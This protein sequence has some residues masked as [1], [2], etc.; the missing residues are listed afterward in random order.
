MSEG[1]PGPSTAGPDGSD[2]RPRPWFDND[3]ERPNPRFAPPHRG[4]FQL[5]YHV[6]RLRIDLRLFSA[7]P[8]EDDARGFDLRLMS[9]V[10]DAGDIPAEGR[11]LVIVAAVGGVLHFRIF[12]GD[13]SIVVD[14]DESHL[15]AQDGPVADLKKRLENLWPTPHP[16]E[17]E[18]GQVI[19]AVTSIVGHSPAKYLLRQFKAPATQF[20]LEQAFQSLAGAAVPRAFSGFCAAYDEIDL[21]FHKLLLSLEGGTRVVVPLDAVDPAFGPLWEAFRDQADSALPAGSPLRVLYD[22]GAAIGDHQLGLLTHCARPDERGVGRP[23]PQIRRLVRALEGLPAAVIRGSPLARLI[24][25]LGPRRGSR[26]EAEFVR[27]FLER[28]GEHCAVGPPPHDAWS[29]YD[30]MKFLYND[31]SNNLLELT[32]ESIA[33]PAGPVRR[34]PD[35]EGRSGT[36]RVDGDVVCTLASQAVNVRRVLDAF[37]RQGWPPVIDNPL[38]ARGKDKDA[39]HK[40]VEQLKNKQGH[41]KFSACDG[42]QSVTWAW[43]ELPGN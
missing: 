16:G 14:R 26:G 6:R 29:L 1:E 40:V 10:G 21:Y 19:T 34:V 18:K 12:G 23:R 33:P 42:A 32:Y 2:P 27:T 28:A 41:I 35:W 38:A 8:E 25:G 15:T 3:Y 11:S 4:A 37:H 17:E 24:V 13:G 7:E 39:V 43:V 22:A 36:L 31:I 30:T 9:A 5:G 20:W